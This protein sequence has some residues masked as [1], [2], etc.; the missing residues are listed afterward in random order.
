MDCSEWLWC[1]NYRTKVCFCNFELIW[2]YDRLHRCWWQVRNV[3]FLLVHSKVTNITLSPKWL[4]PFDPVGW[5]VRFGIR[6]ISSIF[7]M[8]TMTQYFGTDTYSK[9]ERFLKSTE[10]SSLGSKHHKLWS[11]LWSQL[12]SITGMLETT[13]ESLKGKRRID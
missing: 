6:N 9:W 7:R 12:W 8:G 10:N 11:Q 2:S 5:Q 3:R 13:S 4:S 1:R